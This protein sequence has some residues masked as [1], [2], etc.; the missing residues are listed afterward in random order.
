M[1]ALA[2]ATHAFTFEPG[3]VLDGKYRLERVIGEG[4]M[5][6]VWLARNLSLDLP[7]AIKIVQADLHGPAAISRLVTEARAIAQLRHPNIVRVFDCQT[8]GRFAYAVMELLEGCTLA[9]LM[10]EGQLPAQL[11]VRLCLPLLD[12]L[13][14]VHRT[15]IVH[16][17]IKPENVFLARAGDRI[18]PKLIDFGIARHDALEPQRADA[19]QRTG[20]KRLIIGSPGYMAPEQ[21]WGEED[22]DVSADV[23]AIAV[24][25]YEAI[26]GECA[27]PAPTY[28]TFL[29]SL[30]ERELTP[31]RAPGSAGIWQIIAPALAK[32]RAQR[33]ASCVELRQALADWLRKQGQSED[34]SADT[35]S[36]LWAAPGGP[37]ERALRRTQHVART[38]EPSAFARTNLQAYESGPRRNLRPG[39]STIRTIPTSVR[40]ERRVRPWSVF[41]LAAGALIGVFVG[42]GRLSGG[43]DLHA[44]PRPVM[45][46]GLL[47]LSAA[48]PAKPDEIQAPEP[49]RAPI[50]TGV[51]PP[52]VQ[53]TPRNARA[54]RAQHSEAQRV[55]LRREAAALGLKSPW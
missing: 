1:T 16:R 19:P 36:P 40:H 23:W 45:A 15:G 54:P 7:L 2:A 32:Q 35:L 27:F 12:G 31:L 37:L 34:L 10:D 24:V 14:C 4:A 13:A 41:M 43:R 51:A 52:R 29:K 22:I 8:N 11:A 48:A 49:E 3:S 20:S 44:G 18:C 50:E 47:P 28:R 42:H 21:A 9:D 55:Q 33:S 39:P 5:G 30:A 6:R 26:S 46:A 53:R 25:L 38:S 17:D